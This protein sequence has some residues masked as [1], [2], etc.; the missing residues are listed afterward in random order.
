ME[1]RAD[2]RENDISGR[3]TENGGLKTGDEQRYRRRSIHKQGQDWGPNHSMWPNHTI[4]SS[5]SRR[6]DST[7][8]ERKQRGRGTRA[9]CFHVGNGNVLLFTWF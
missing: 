7:E 1:S 8:V 9:W 6:L 4:W 2:W 3:G 5:S